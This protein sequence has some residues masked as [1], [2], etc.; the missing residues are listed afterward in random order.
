MKCIAKGL[1]AFL[2]ITLL[3]GCSTAAKTSPKQGENNTVDAEVI[4]WCESY[5]TDVYAY[6][7]R[8]TPQLLRIRNTTGESYHEMTMRGAAAAAK[9]Y[10]KGK[11]INRFPVERYGYVSDIHLINSACGAGINNADTG[12]PSEHVRKVIQEGL[13]VQDCKRH[14]RQR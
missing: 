13:M 5:A 11:L 9:L 14:A 4:A 12:A 1:F 2:F 3:A 8:I 10:P 6:C 7:Y